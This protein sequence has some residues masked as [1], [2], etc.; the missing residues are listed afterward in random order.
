VSTWLDHII[1]G[2]YRQLANGGNRVMANFDIKR[3]AVAG[4]SF[5]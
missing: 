2:L 4:A 3:G 1:A 5:K